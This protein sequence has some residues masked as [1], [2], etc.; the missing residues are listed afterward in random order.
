MSSLSNGIFSGDRPLFDLGLLPTGKRSLVNS[1]H[2]GSKDLIILA[3]VLSERGCL[4]S[5]SFWVIGFRQ[6]L[7]RL[8]GLISE[9]AA[10][11]FR[12]PAFLQAIKRRKGAGS[13][14]GKFL[15]A[16]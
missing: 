3:L 15:E 5:Y 16:S 10:S 12:A 8:C 14:T 6:P 11:V 9:A 2:G 4:I 13:V 7:D 1:N